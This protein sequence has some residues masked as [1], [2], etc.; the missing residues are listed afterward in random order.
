MTIVHDPA[1]V[2]KS[3]KAGVGG[4]LTTE[5]GR[6]TA[7]REAVVVHGTVRAI[8]DGNYEEPTPTHGGFRFFDMGEAA[9]VELSGDNLV[10]LTSRLTLPTSVQQLRAAGIEPTERALIVA[11]GRR[12][13]AGR[14]RSGRGGVRARRHPRRHQRRP[15]R[16]RVRAPAAA[17]AS[18]RDRAGRAGA[19]SEPVLRS[20][21]VRAISFEGDAL[22]LSMDWSLADL[23]RPQVL[24]ETAAGASH[25]SSYH[26][27]ELGTEAANGVLQAGAKPAEYTTTD[28]RDGVAQAH[29]GMNYPLAT[30]ELIADLVEA[31][32]N[33]TP[34][35]AVVLA[36]AGDKAV[37]RPTCS[38]S[39][40]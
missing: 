15:R 2:A 10:L 28:I 22:R 11:K 26:L 29:S 9:V 18:V 6:P 21:A 38:R 8:V 40:D 35:D 17:V 36:S 25:P 34:F 12:L 32:V 24:V 30:R 7:G 31:H 20:Q 5:I 3:V 1:A 19:V 4:S 23:D 39:P 33:A 13:A 37:R 16:L 27:A 14:L